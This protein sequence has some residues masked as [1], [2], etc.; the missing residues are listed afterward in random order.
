MWLGVCVSEWCVCGVWCV[1]VCLCVCVFVFRN[2]STVQVAQV[3]YTPA[4]VAVSW[5]CFCL[6][7]V[8]FLSPGGVVFVSRWCSLACF[9]DPIYGARGRTNLDVSQ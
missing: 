1:P 8:L 4:L 6:Q 9:L 7:V 5:C 3:Q 2:Q